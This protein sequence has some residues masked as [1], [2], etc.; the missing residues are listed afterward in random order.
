MEVVFVHIHKDVRK[1]RERK[2]IPDA[3]HG[4]HTKWK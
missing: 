2:N 4:N 3:L 1:R